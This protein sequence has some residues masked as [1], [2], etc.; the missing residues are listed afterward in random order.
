M[1][2]SD[3]GDI[4]IGAQ[5][6]TIEDV[7]RVAR[8]GAR[9]G[10]AAA[11]RERVAASRAVIDRLAQ[12]TAGVY[13]LTTGLGAGVDT[14][15]SHDDQIAFQYSIARARSAGVGPALQ[16]AVARALML[17]RAN[18]IAAGGSGAAPAVMETLVDALN[19]GFHPVL[20]SKGS[21]GAG[22]MAQ[23]ACIAR[24]LVGEP[25]A[26]VDVG[27][28][29]LA[30]PEAL[31]RVGLRPLVLSGKDGLALVA[32]G[33]CSTGHGALVLADA[34]R[35]MTA[36]DA[37][38]ALALEAFRASLE[39]LDPR[40]IA[41]RPSPGVSEAAA[42]IRHALAGSRLWAKGAARR[43]QDPLSFRCVAQIH[44]AALDALA[45]A[46][47]LVEININTASDNPLVVADDGEVLHNGNFDLSAMAFAFEGAGLAL[48][49]VAT[50]SV[51]R[52]MKLM[53][54]T[55]SGLPR[56][57][58]PR[59]QNRAGFAPT[60]KTLA[61]LE[62][63]IRHLALP[64]A[65]PPIPVADGVEDVAQMA[66][67][68]VDKTEAILDRLRWITAI[69]LIVAAQAA[70]LRPVDPAAMG[71]HARAAYAFTRARVAA[72]DDDRAH[73]AD[74][75]RL[76]EDLARGELLLG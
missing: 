71:A 7:T 58:T 57:L 72:L 70:D 18:C 60:Q 11:A 63:E 73:G 4:V 56:F 61:G 22:D 55:L 24:A 75:D 17:V 9:V 32:A 76:A 30:A 19:A 6:L 25:D 14:R 39:P 52:A 53:S 64:V 2:S 23:L 45:R 34:E 44:G 37:A 42:R 28:A 13:G 31:A 36:V 69:G 21:H 47:A 8:G 43:V 46:R 74:Y 26:M 33:G 12:G 48:A 1:T 54:P 59:G 62:G 65:F 29:V 27:G 41:A 15:L 67:A 40:V 5:A 10:I 68:A 16:V 50:A 3:R 20:P 49:H 51:H 38:A 66:P 35:L